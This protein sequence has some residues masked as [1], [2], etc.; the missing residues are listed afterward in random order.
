MIERPMIKRS[1][2]LIILA[3][4]VIAASGFLYNR[5]QFNKGNEIICG[6][7]IDNEL[8]TYINLSKNGDIHVP[9]RNVVLTVADRTVAFTAS[10]CP[11][12]ICIKSG[13]LSHPG[14]MAV[15]M[16]NKVSVKII[17][18]NAYNAP[19]LIAW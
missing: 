16:P 3:L 12:K 13:P 18:S 11:D 10:D 4:L 8:F 7:Y 5:A 17:S 14:Q 19:D 1:D 6:L 9:G 15:C 2:L